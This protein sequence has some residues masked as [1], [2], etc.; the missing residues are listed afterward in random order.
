[1]ISRIPFRFTLIILLIPFLG[2]CRKDHTY[3]TSEDPDLKWYLHLS[4]TRT[5]SSPSMD[6]T[7]EKIHFKNYDMLWLGGDLESET[8]RDS[9]TIS[10]AD[11]IFDLSYPDVLWALGNHDYSDLSMVQATTGRAP[12]YTYTKNKITFLVLD[13]QDSMSN[14]VGA[15]LNLI[16]AV[17]DTIQN[18][19]HLILLHH[20]LIWMY[21][22]PDLEN[23]ITSVTNG[24]FGTCFYC[25]NPNNFYTDV[26]PKLL[27]VKQR[28]IEVICIGGDIGINAKTFEYT[29]SD[30]IHFLAS[31]IS[32]G[33]SGNK[34][35]LFQHNVRTHK[36]TWEYKDLENL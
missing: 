27:S 23:S 28:G 29:T 35:L 32:A 21:N 16:N 31:G 30:G 7:A 18:S 36:L 15:Q 17:T 10:F 12:F 24:G 9:A 34:A 25:I 2:A 20:Q 11:S 26:Y 4:H 19:T 13:T 14:F 22:N 5:D 8:A 33:D 3:L 6:A 1:M